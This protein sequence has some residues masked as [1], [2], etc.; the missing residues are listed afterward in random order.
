M[1]TLAEATA[2]DP[3]LVVGLMTGTSLDGLDIVLCRIAKGVPHG[4]EVVASAHEPM[5]AELR[6]GLLQGGAL[7]VQEA[8]R[9]S[10][11]LGNWYAEAT[12]ALCRRAGLRPQLVGMHGQTVYHEHGV[13]TVQ[14]GEP[15]FLAREL[16]C[17]VI[18]DFRQG[19]IAAGGCGAPLVPFVDRW[20]LSRPDIGVVALNIGGITN[21]TALP[22]SARM[23]GVIGFDCGPGNMILDELARRY[24]GGALTADMD[25]AFARRG[26]V[27]EDWLEAL[28]AHPFLAERP[29]R[30]A[31]R[32]QFGAHYVDELLGR[33][34]PADERA[35]L[36][37]FATASEA[38]V[39][40][41]VDAV[42]RFV[43]E[44]FATRELVVGGGGARNPALMERFRAR[45]P[46]WS[47]VT[48]D[49][50]GVPVDLKEAIAFAIL[51][52]ARLDGIPTNC[53]E[54][55]GAARRVLLG[56]ITEWAAPGE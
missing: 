52:S 25:G 55:T 41:V 53:P 54:V 2:T 1:V 13:V 46:G 42:E 34:A 10:R 24:T 11:A 27:C 23:E 6:S 40:A 37:L 9:L 17:P 45:L 21:I 14:L 30:S 44:A 47:V 5:P 12:A 48:S 28:L 51:A 43:P 35:W 29:P 22:P 49:V 56:K 33:F 18:S 36:D 7:T 39:R 50:R 38:T 4:V 16:G 31:G 19:D 15:S 26:T 3:R 8:A 20:L 32:E